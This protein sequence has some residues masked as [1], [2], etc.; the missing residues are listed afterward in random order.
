M[1]I[2]FKNSIGDIPMEVKYAL[3]LLRGGELPEDE[4]KKYHKSLA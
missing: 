2:E 1:G 4:A 3:M